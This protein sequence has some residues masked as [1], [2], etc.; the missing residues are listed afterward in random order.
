MFDQVLL[1]GAEPGANGG[2]DRAVL[3]LLV[4]ERAVAEFLDQGATIVGADGGQFEVGTPSGEAVEAGDP[5]FHGMIPFLE[6]ESAGDHFFGQQL[7]GGV[8]GW[9][10]DAAG[11]QRESA[12]FDEFLGLDP[13]G[14]GIEEDPEA[15]GDILGKE[16]LEPGRF[17]GRGEG[18]EGVGFAASTA[19]FTDFGND[20]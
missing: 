19:D 17:D 16:V 8:G 9:G 15:A 4:A 2:F 13:T 11:L 12:K 3:D 1:V 6:V 18:E 5:L 20:E 14:G 10:F 7:G